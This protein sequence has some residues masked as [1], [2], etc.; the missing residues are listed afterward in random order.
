MFGAVLEGWWTSSAATALLLTLTGDVAV[1][2]F[3]ATKQCCLSLCMQ[4]NARP[5]LACAIC[6]AS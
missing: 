4:M 5:H 2:A 3:S 6:N 1:H